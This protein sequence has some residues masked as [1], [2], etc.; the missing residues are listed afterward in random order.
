MLECKAKEQAQKEIAEARKKAFEEVRQRSRP[1]LTADCRL[2]RQ[3][4]LSVIGEARRKAQ[5]EAEATAKKAM[6]AKLAQ[7]QRDREDL[8]A[9]RNGSSLHD[10]C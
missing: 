9:V 6:E 1:K 8:E 7:E 5:A 3:Q 10:C 4:E 2:Q